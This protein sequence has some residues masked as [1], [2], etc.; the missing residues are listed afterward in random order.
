MPNSINRKRRSSTA[1]AI[2]SV[3]AAEARTGLAVFFAPVVAVGRTIAGSL[4][5]PRS[6]KPHGADQVR[7][8]VRSQ[9][10]RPAFMT[11]SAEEI[12]ARQMRNMIFHG[13]V[14][15]APARAE[16]DKHDEAVRTP[17]HQ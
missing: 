7:P 3:I 6:A 1:A 4:A 14:R 10:E 9:T 5:D 17:V 12:A 16:R 8:T 2:A 15:P 13:P 11:R